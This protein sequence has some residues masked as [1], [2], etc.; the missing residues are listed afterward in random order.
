MLL[1]EVG[2]NRHESTERVSQD[3]SEQELLS[4]N[5]GPAGC[6]VPQR[7]RSV[8]VPYRP[9]ELLFPST[10]Q[11]GAVGAGNFQS[12]GHRRVDAA[13]VHGSKLPL[14]RTAQV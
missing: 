13:R 1:G 7:A 2:L 6:S 3:H 9:G 4:D 12:L 8:K 10:L 5:K 11:G 14:R